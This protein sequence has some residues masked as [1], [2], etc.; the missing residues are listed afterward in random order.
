MAYKDPDKQREWDRK[1]HAKKKDDPDYKQRRKEYEKRYRET[2]KEQSRA[3]QREWARRNK[4]KLKLK[5]AK[6]YAKNKERN[7]ATARAWQ[8]KNKQHVAEYKKRPDVIA[9]H[10]AWHRSKTV[11]MRAL[12]IGQ[13]GGICACCRET[14]L[15][16]LTIDHINGNGNE[17]RRELKMGGG[18]S[19]YYWLRRNGYP[20]GYQVLCM[21]CNWSRGVYGF[22]PHEKAR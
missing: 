10:N 14:A 4:E 1:R 3:Y 19:F 18:K 11:E 13:Y 6:W 9:R 15:Q 8:E 20:K 2:H 16:F 12:V 22:C 17:H 7:A 5:F 21:N